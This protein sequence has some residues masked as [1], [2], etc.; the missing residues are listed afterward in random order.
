MP[1]LSPYPL[2]DFRGFFISGLAVAGS[3][4]TAP[5]NYRRWRL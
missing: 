5:R 1:R 4:H 3:I 2:L